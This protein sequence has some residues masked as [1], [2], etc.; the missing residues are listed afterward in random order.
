MRRWNQR[1]VA[2]K[3]SALYPI[4]WRNPPILGIPPKLGGSPLLLVGYP[5]FPCLTARTFHMHSVS[6]Y[7]TVLCQ[8][9]AYT[10]LAYTRISGMR[11]WFECL[12]SMCLIPPCRTCGRCPATGGVRE[13]VLP[14]EA[15]QCSSH[16]SLSQSRLS[17]PPG[18][19]FTQIKFR[20]ASQMA[21]QPPKRGKGVE[22]SAKNLR[23]RQGWQS[24][25]L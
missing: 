25:Y 12:P 9:Q 4:F 1:E 2:P 19:F 21:K 13:I 15:R 20:K 5:L 7:E 18:T 17:F 22:S 10:P 3:F 16:F 14:E 8:Q 6:L 24:C 23:E 11:D